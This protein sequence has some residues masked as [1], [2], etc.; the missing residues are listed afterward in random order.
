MD[1][2]KAARTLATNELEQF[3]FP[4]KIHFEISEKKA[5]ELTKKLNADQKITKIGIYLMDLKLGQ[6]IKENKLNDHIKMGSKTAKDFLKDKELTKEEKDKI[7]NC[8]EAHHKEVPFTCLEAEICANADC[9]RFIHPKGF[10]AFLHI[11][12]KR[13]KSF[14]ESLDFA[15]SKLDEKYNN[16]S[17][18]HCKDELEPFYQTLKKYIEA[19]RDF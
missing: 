12:G 9:Y 7:I 14:Q 15:E 2:P 19:A 11:L 17:L 3:G 8:I 6:A 13:N 5:L 1:I 10:F 4:T 16:L 18:K